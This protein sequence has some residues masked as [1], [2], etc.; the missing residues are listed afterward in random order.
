LLPKFLLKVTERAGKVVQ[1]A[2]RVPAEQRICKTAMLMYNQYV[3]T[4]RAIPKI[5]ALPGKKCADSLT[6]GTP[7]A[8]LRTGEVP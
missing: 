2:D 6:R 4:G 7:R 3:G 1:R 5:H 8:A